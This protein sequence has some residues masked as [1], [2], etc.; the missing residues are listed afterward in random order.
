[1]IE[2]HVQPFA[3]ELDAEQTEQIVGEGF[4]AFGRCLEDEQLFAARYAY[5]RSYERFLIE[6][7]EE[8][9]EGRIEYPCPLENFCHEPDLVSLIANPT[10]LAI[11]RAACE[12]DDVEYTGGIL[13]RTSFFQNK[14]AASGATWHADSFIGKNAEPGRDDRVAIWYYFDDVTGAEGATE[15]I[16]GTYKIVQQ[17]FREGKEGA[18]GLHEIL[19]ERNEAP[20]EDRVYAAAPAG[21]GMAFKSFVFHRATDNK[22]GI[23]RRVMTMDYR[24]KGTTHVDDGNFQSL[25]HEKREAMREMLPEEARD[26]MVI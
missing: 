1:M 9:A 10:I 17:N 26:L 11:A 13:R 19:V 25:P 14:V 12:T 20:V 2:T 7:V 22:S 6:D 5:E 24:V 3:A 4:L 15:M 21:G 18:E 16:P 23:C 8:A